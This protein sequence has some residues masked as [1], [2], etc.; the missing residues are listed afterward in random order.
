M[1]KTLYK[2]LYEQLKQ[3]IL[4]G[5][6]KAGEQIPSELD[7]ASAF[8]V[9]RITSKKALEMLASEGLVERYVGRGTF[10][11]SR[12]APPTKRSSSKKVIGLVM[13]DMTDHYG[14][15]IISSIEGSA[16]G[17]CIIIVRFTNGIPE[18]EDDA[19][20]EL[21]EFGVD[22]LIVFPAK[23]EYLNDRILQLVI[24]QFP[25]VVVDRSINGL[26]MVSV[27]TDNAGAVQTGLE[28]L[29][30]LGHEHIAILSPPLQSNNV[31][32]E[33]SKAVIQFSAERGVFF[34]RKHWLTSI[35]TES[36]HYEKEAEKITGHLKQYPEITAI[37]AFEYKIALLAE[38]AVKRLSKQIGKD[39]DLIC[40]DSPPT[41]F[42]RPPFTHLH[43]NIGRNRTCGF[44]AADPPGRSE[45]K[46]CDPCRPS[47]WAL[48]QKPW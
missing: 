30:E 2:N 11:K 41:I 9:S 43:Q 48:D 23:S 39:I 24:T 42:G 44:D 5:V 38:E 32:E 13:V 12:T 14:T 4:S 25:I 20:K 26:N 27:S 34:Q 16:A 8:G 10:V 47:D 21:I 17:K 28:L 35:Q 29:T 3:D 46:T 7:L 15:E 45:E 31:L 36:I 37:F 1:S 40:F 33:R 22:G 6:Y 18:K 19:I